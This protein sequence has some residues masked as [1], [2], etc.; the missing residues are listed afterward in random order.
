MKGLLIVACALLVLNLV[1][2]GLA[3]DKLGQ[4]L[5]IL[6]HPQEHQRVLDQQVVD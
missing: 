5:W 6:C 3:V 1:L 2:L 4:I